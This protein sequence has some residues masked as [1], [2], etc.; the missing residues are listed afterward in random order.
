MSKLKSYIRLTLKAIFWVAVSLVLIFILIAVLIQVPSIQTKIVHYATT[1]VSNKTHTKVEIKNVSISFPKAV[2][3]EGLYLEDLKYDTLVYAQKAK[4][5]MALYDLLHN[6][7]AVSF[8]ALEDATIK[9]HST[10]TD[11]IFNYN[12]LLTAFSLSL[13]HISE[14]TRLGMI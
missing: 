9:L 11:P 8:F 13:I 3:I 2:V 6:K 1:F 4:I 7:I 14:P 5:N 10:K 12:F